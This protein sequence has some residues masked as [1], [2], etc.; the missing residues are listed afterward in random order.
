MMHRFIHVGRAAV[1]AIAFFTVS[2]SAG[3]QT[4]SKV[5]VAAG[6][7]NE[8]TA[9]FGTITCL[10]GT[11]LSDPKGPPCSPG[12]TRF[13]M[14][15]TVRTCNF[16]ELSGSAAPL[17]EDATIKNV[18]HC[19][20]DGNYYG[21]CWGHSVITVPKAGGQW[22]G[23]WSGKWDMLMNISSWTSTLYGYGGKLEG[24]Q[25]QIEGASTTPGQPFVVILKVNGR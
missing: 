12:T 5:L 6:R 2:T 18:V 17:F 25:A 4:P 3:A 16:I 20:T 23:A 13:L 24:L 15:Y 22:E 7:Q 19:N 21:H 9:V 1:A 14:S 10:N 11:P 8:G